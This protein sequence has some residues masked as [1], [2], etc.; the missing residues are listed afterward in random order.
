MVSLQNFGRRMQAVEQRYENENSKKDAVSIK[1]RK[2]V[3][4]GAPE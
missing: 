1:I 4:G 3:Q 2:P